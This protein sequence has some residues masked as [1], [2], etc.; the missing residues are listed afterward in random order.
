VRSPLG[1]HYRTTTKR[2]AF[3][4]GNAVRLA[5][6]D[7][8]EDAAGRTMDVGRCAIEPREHGGVYAT[9]Q[10]A[11]Y[12]PHARPLADAL[13]Y[14]VIRGDDRELTVVLTVGDLNAQ[15]ART[16]TTVSKRLTRG[17]AG[18]TGVLLYEDRSDG[19]YY[20][21][22]QNPSARGVMRKVYGT[23][24]MYARFGGKGFL[25][26]GTAFSQ[27]NASLVD[28]MLAEA[29]R[30]LRPGSASTFFD[31]YCGYGLFTLTVGTTAGSAVGVER[32]PESISAA[33]ANGRRHHARNV[34]FVR[35]AIT[36]ETTGPILAQARPGDV[37]L[38]DP[39][40]GGAGA[41]VLESIAAR[42]PARV[43]H[44]FCNVDLVGPEIERWKKSGYRLADAVPFDMFPGTDD[45]EIMAL[46]A[47]AAGQGA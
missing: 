9:V 21:G 18:I 39:P 3:H 42:K 45:V 29:A 14:V 8:S 44:L 19:R 38:L 46:F 33:I 6:I 30:L 10:E 27:I 4:R 25:Y 34:R 5:L 28:G 26:P 24:E 17:H 22:M 12:A 31:L 15:V 32:S 41:G 7:P 37:V 40:R 11:L 16:A 35:N 43:L 1:R 2:K 23:G 20:F 47:P 36:P 13:R